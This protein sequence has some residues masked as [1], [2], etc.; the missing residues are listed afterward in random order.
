MSVLAIL[1]VASIVAC[2][3]V[4]LFLVYADRPR[5]TAKEWEETILLY[6]L[7]G[8]TAEGPFT[9][10]EVCSRSLHLTEFARVLT[11]SGTLPSLAEAE[12]V[13]DAARGRLEARG[14]CVRLT[15][16]E[17]SPDGSLPPRM[18]VVLTPQGGREALEVWRRERAKARMEEPVR[19]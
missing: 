19:G 13:L 5:V 12:R 9:E 4:G 15:P 18:L 7:G 3:A 6:V 16:P 11:A 17:G 2:A 10:R 8:P 14:A 1:F